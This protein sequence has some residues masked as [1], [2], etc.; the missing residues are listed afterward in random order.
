MANVCLLRV[1]DSNRTGLVEFDRIYNLFEE[2]KSLAAVGLS[3]FNDKASQRPK[4]DLDVL[5]H[6]LCKLSTIF[7]TCT[8]PHQGE[9]LINPEIPK[10]LEMHLTANE[11]SW[12]RNTFDQ[13]AVQ[14]R[15]V[16]PSTKFFTELFGLLSHGTVVSPDFSVEWL[17]IVT[18]RV[19]RVLRNVPEFQALSDRDQ[20]N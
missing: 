8:L 5:V 9:E 12:I 2:S 15:S 20:V 18:E 4:F 14:F 6:S 10:P 3:L 17:A 13:V 11:E 1:N 16:V 7:G 19:R